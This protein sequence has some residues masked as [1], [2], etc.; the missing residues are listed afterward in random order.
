MTQA[1]TAYGTGV[2]SKA[3]QDPRAGGVLWIQVMSPHRMNQA[4]DFVR[5]RGERLLAILE[6]QG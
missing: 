6:Y 4:R 1:T 5:H 3:A 2:S